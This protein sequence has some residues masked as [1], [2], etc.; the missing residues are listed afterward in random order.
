MRRRDFLLGTAALA[1]GG[2][3]LF[4]QGQR[5]EAS[6][7]YPGRQ[8]GHWLRDNQ[9][10]P[11]PSETL[12]TEVL[13]A[14]SG[15]AGLTAAW[16]LKKNGVS[17]LLVVSGPEPHGNAAGGADG[18]LQFPTG[19]HYLPLPSMESRHIREM[20]FEFGILQK[21]PYAER[22]TYDERYLVH[23]PGERV[24]YQG[25]WQEG[26]LPTD[27]V[28]TEERS[29][30][31]RFFD[32]VDYYS[33]ARG[34]DGRRAFAVP[35]VESS[36]DQ[37]FLDLDKTS[38]RAWLVKAEL[39]GAT[40]LWYLDYCC[41]DDYGRHLDEISAWAGVALFLLARWRSSQC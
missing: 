1:G 10:L 29:Q 23:A 38:F 12:E 27:G 37:V 35:L 36:Q 7:E 28:S 18:E 15:V 6:A 5:I 39:D 8:F 22:P 41:R 33:K 4:A 20:L 2:G 21:D 11:A 3:A 9:T 26:Y 40:L 34:Q 25:A 16:S 13:I 17:D 30:H 19:A 14:G 31:R 24:L 32:I